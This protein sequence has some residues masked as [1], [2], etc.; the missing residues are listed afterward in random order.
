M[1]DWESDNGE[2]FIIDGPLDYDQGEM[3]GSQM[4]SNMKASARGQELIQ[5]IIDDD[6]TYLENS[7]DLK[8]YEQLFESE[9]LVE[10][11]HYEIYQLYAD[12][13][14]QLGYNYK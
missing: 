11:L 13:F 4:I 7:A 5:M 2:H 6:N 3:A 8:K 9:L 14:N 10:D 1:Q 12:A